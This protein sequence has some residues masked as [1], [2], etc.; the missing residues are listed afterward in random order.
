ML[1]L[2]I[3]ILETVFVTI[4]QGFDIFKVGTHFATKPKEFKQLGQL[5]NVLFCKQGLIFNTI[6]LPV[7]GVGTCLIWKGVVAK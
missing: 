2:A 1:H 7:K 5:T 3:H 6:E 4:F